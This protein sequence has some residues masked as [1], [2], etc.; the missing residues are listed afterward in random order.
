VRQRKKPGQ[1]LTILG[2]GNTLCTDDGL[3]PAV[4]A[5]LQ[6]QWHGDGVAI[7][8]GGTLGM[9]LLPLL[10]DTEKLLLVD[11][12]RTDDPPGSLVRLEGED[13]LPAVRLRLSPHQV[14]VADLLDSARLLG[15]M[16]DKVILIGLVPESIGLGF[17]LTE[18]IAAA[19]PTLTEAILKEAESLGHRLEAGGEDEAVGVA[20][21]DPGEPQMRGASRAR[22]S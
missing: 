6:R 16:P 14:G 9:S 3:G 5:S 1:P 4:V 10:E 18:R 21:P 15:T 7:V 17:G 13:V 12:I 8:D 19:L 2:V 22:P 20:V 11:A